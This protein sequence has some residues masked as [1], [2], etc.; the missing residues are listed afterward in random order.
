MNEPAWLL[1]CQRILTMP[2]K[3]YVKRSVSFL[4]ASEIA[5]LLSAPD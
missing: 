1:H 3:R 4:D 5:A 2:S